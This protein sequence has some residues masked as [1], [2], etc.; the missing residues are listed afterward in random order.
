M[1]KRA[2]PLVL[3]LALPAC[4]DNRLVLLADPDGTVGRI[5]V[6]TAAGTQ[7]L[8]RPKMVTRVADGDSRPTPPKDISDAEIEKVWGTAL[9]AMPP[10]PETT[11]LYFQTGGTELTAESAGALPDLAA[12]IRERAHPRVLVVGHADATGSD[13]VN[14]T[15]SR[16]RAAF[17]R[18]RLAEMGVPAQVMEVTSHGKRNPLVRTPDGVPEPRN[19][20]VSVTVQ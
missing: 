15:V 20:R 4:A 8:E 12:R 9:A 17:V 5:E 1:N 3:A 16:D 11:L 19:R 2:L 10:R 14:I 18:D 7:L 6:S 13:A